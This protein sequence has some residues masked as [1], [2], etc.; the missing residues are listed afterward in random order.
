MCRHHCC[1]ESTSDKA[2]NV[3]PLDSC[4]NYCLFALHPSKTMLFFIIF[5]TINTIIL[6]ISLSLYERDL[7]TFLSENVYGP[8]LSIKQIAKVIKCNKKMMQCW[9][10]RWKQIK[11]F[12][13]AE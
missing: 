8:K 2:K 13:N 11:D 10:N 3:R 5:S 7:I 6:K 12:S 1:N 4:K 9:L